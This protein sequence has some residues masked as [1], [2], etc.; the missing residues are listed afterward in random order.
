VGRPGRASIHSADRR[1]IVSGMS[2]AENLVLVGHLTDLAKQVEEK[3]GMSLPFQRGQ[4]LGVMVQST[5]SPDSQLL[6][7]QG[8][9][10]GKFYQRLIVPGFPRLD[11]EDLL[12]GACWLL[13]NRYAAEYT[14]RSQRTGMGAAVDDWISSGLAQNTQAALYARNREWISREWTEG[15]IMSLQN[16]IKQ[17]TLPPGRWREKA[18]A[19]AAVEF[20][21]PKGDLTTWAMLFKAVGTRQPI[22]GTW[23]RK[24]CPALQNRHPEEAWREYLKQRSRSHTVA[25]WSDRGLQIEAKLLQTLNFRPRELISDVPADVPVDLYARDLMTY[26]G[27][28]WT[29]P[30][31]GSLSLRMQSLELGAPSALRGVLSS[32]AAFFNQLATPPAPKRSWWK[33]GRKD[34]KKRQPPD[35]ATW[36]VALNQLWMRAERAHQSFL[37]NHQTAKR[38]VDSFDRPVSGNFPDPLASSDEGPRTRLQQAVDAIE[39]QMNQNPF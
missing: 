15:Q 2:S 31:A 18:Y 16:V 39:E 25:A 22:D 12:G 20:L 17:K 34:P 4:V 37:E 35:D 6:K 27:Q 38:Y 9:D 28:E 26:R 19:S 8:W 36:L 32:Y 11:T 29:F 24:H 5:S 3:T 30:V 21:F 33:R 14:P 23:L 1:F 7:M 13:L 10:G